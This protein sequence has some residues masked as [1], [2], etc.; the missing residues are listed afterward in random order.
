MIV[1][2]W[3]GAPEK[4]RRLAGEPL[5]VAAR[6]VA[7]RVGAML[8]VRGFYPH[9]EEPESVSGPRRRNTRSGGF[10]CLWGRDVGAAGVGLA[11]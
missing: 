9:V 6:V 2:V 11:W 8:V 1:G 7:E 4:Y 3:A 5:L 10:G